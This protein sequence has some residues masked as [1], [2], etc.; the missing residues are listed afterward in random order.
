MYGV[1][2]AA[3]VNEESPLDPKTEYAASK[4][5]A[6]DAIRQLAAR[7]F[8]PVFLR[9]GTVYG[10]SPRMR[11]DTVL[12]DLVGAA[13]TTGKVT[14]YG[15][16]APWRP[17]VH[18]EDVSRAF[19]EVLGAPRDTIHNQ[20]FNLGADEFNT[21]IRRL[22]EMVTAAVPGAQLEVLN[23]AGADQRTYITDFRKFGA[24]F[25]DFRFLWN[26]ERGAKQLY[27]AL[28][29]L[30]LTHEQFTDKKYTRLKWLNHL[31]QSQQ[32]DPS[33]RW[34]RTEAL[35]AAR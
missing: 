20:A 6:E 12:N 26:P 4:V 13:I 19:L 2:E 22:A 24:A 1:S 8:S 10:R 33:L 25:P 5:K 35:H 18:V 23:Q 11:F 3:V 28:T 27:G 32:L 17:V 15:G 34:A 16:G 30:G 31:L 29:E 21:Q 7:D 14:V 9:N